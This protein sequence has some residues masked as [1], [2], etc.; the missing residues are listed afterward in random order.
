MATQGRV[1]HQLHLLEI[2]RRNIQI[3]LTQIASLGSNQIV[4]AQE[5]Q[6]SAARAKVNDIKNILRNWRYD[7]ADHPDDF[8]TATIAV[9]INI[10]EGKCILVIPKEDM[11]FIRQIYPELLKYVVYNS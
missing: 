2:Y 4:V 3:L 9:Q 5:N 8:N 11:N 10:S 7:I 6:L 1:D